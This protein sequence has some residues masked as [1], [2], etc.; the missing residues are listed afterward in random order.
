MSNI[1]IYDSFKY[2]ASNMYIYDV[3]KEIIYIFV[4]E[5]CVH[6]RASVQLHHLTTDSL[7]LVFSQNSSGSL[8]KLAKFIKLNDE[9]VF[10]ARSK[11][12]KQ[13]YKRV[14]R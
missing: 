7:E 4:K 11:L 6:L 1:V 3:S 8:K 5:R 9:H 13:L 10:G 12:L 2:N 14:T